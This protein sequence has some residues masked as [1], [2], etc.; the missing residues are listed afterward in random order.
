MRTDRPLTDL[1]P[2]ATAVVAS[3]LARFEV[4]DLEVSD[5]PIEELIGGL[6]RE[7]R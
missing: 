6:F 4:L 2:G 7:A 3:L 5:P 1:R